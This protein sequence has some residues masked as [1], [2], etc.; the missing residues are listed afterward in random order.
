M[1]LV[2]VTN[3]QAM[4]S[5]GAIPGGA[6]ASKVSSLPHGFGAFIFAIP[7]CAAGGTLLHSA[8]VWNTQHRELTSEEATTDLFTCAFPPLFFINLMKPSAS[9]PKPARRP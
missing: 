8:I 6:G 9:A 4:D 2:G 3:S 1:L 5:I 7:F